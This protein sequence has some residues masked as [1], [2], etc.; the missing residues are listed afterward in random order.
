MITAQSQ[1]VVRIRQKGRAWVFTPK[2]FLDIATR[3]ATDQAL[4]RLVRSGT[5]RRIARGIY[6][7]P[8]TNARLKLDVP[9]DPDSIAQAIARNTGSRIA[10]SGATAANRLGLSTQVPAKPIYDSN[11]RPRQIRVGG[12]LIQ[13]KHVS[14]K[15]LP[16]CGP[17]SAMVFQALRHLGRD[18]VDDR[19]ISLIRRRLSPTQRNRLLHD[20]R[21][22]HDWVVDKA[23]RIAQ[24]QD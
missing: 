21:C 10:P 8:I 11:G 24:T 4:S 19:A 16:N 6:Q 15:K 3:A 20:A 13:I 23:R 17:A 1:I 12:T 22:T 7:R 2:D 14:P 5:V 9:P 18:G